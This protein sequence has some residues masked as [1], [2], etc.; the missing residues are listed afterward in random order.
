MAIPDFNI[1]PMP[2]IDISTGL[3]FLQQQQEN[4][5]KEASDFMNARARMEQAQVDRETNAVRMAQLAEDRRQF[6]LKMP[7]LQQQADTDRYEAETD[8]REFNDRD[9]QSER[10]IREIRARERAVSLRNWQEGLKVLGKVAD[11]I[12]DIVVG[13]L[14]IREETINGQNAR[15]LEEKRKETEGARLLTQEERTETA[16]VTADGRLKVEQEDT[17]QARIKANADEYKAD[18]NLIMSQH[19]V[20]ISKDQTERSENALKIS[21]NKLRAELL[22][23][24]GKY[25]EQVAEAVEAGASLIDAITALPREALKRSAELAAARSRVEEAGIRKQQ[26]EGSDAAAKDRQFVERLMLQQRDRM[27]Q[28]LISDREKGRKHDKDMVVHRAMFSATDNSQVV[29]EYATGVL[30]DLA[31]SDTE[32]VIEA[33]GHEKLS[34]KDAEMFLEQATTAKLQDVWGKMSALAHPP[35]RLALVQGMLSS[36]EKSEI[37]AFKDRVANG[38]PDTEP[39]NAS[40]LSGNYEER[41]AQYL[42]NAL[43]KV[44]NEQESFASSVGDA[45]VVVLQSSKAALRQVNN[46]EQGFMVEYDGRINRIEGLINNFPTKPNAWASG[47]Y[48]NKVVEGLANIAETLDEKVQAYEMTYGAG[49]GSVAAKE[50]YVQ[51]MLSQFAHSSMSDEEKGSVYDKMLASP[52]MSM[53]LSSDG[54]DPN[55][56]AE[57]K[58]LRPGRIEAIQPKSSLSQSDA[59]FAAGIMNI[60]PTFTVSLDGTKIQTAHSKFTGGAPYSFNKLFNKNVTYG[61]AEVALDNTVWEVAPHP[62]GVVKDGEFD[63][64]ISPVRFL[65]PNQS[66]AMRLAKH[67]WED[68]HGLDS[69]RGFARYLAE[70]IPH[71]GGP[72]TD[73]ELRL[74]TFLTSKAN[75]DVSKH[76]TAYNTIVFTFDAESGTY[77]CALKPKD[78][79]GSPLVVPGF[80]PLVENYRD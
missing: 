46:R 64:K 41:A 34:D 44:S 9:A 26:Q 55:S 5:M 57:I 30:S 11:G 12:G 48:Y 17:L 13:Y 65:R 59:D 51:S 4:L 42:A 18:I 35:E 70:F 22:A 37:K 2:P 68:Q 16:R 53:V 39:P 63:L 1:Q 49:F 78:P 73:V 32:D 60:V 38:A 67:E 75:V 14:D 15:D 29:V 76:F 62:E 21:E 19:R 23:L 77:E 33:L 6:D 71:S 7:L 36:K 27:Q 47:K 72:K 54:I 50:R 24:P 61:D 52:K 58:R 28:S 10:Q 3:R 8:R 40:N 45:P 69:R 56:K 66:P 79:K 20:Q 80:D 74:E 25:I 31:N 43:S